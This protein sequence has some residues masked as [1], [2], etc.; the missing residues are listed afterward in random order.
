MGTQRML[1]TERVRS[2]MDGVERV[3]SEYQNKDA[4]TPTDSAIAFGR[5]LGVIDY[6]RERFGVTS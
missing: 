1:E 2:L 4:P 3:I 6:Y 5:V